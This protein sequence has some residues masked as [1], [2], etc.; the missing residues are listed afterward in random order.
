MAVKMILVRGLPGSGKSTVAKKWLLAAKLET[1][2]YW[3]R[4]DGT[5][6]F[7]PRLLSEAHQWC[8]NK[9][10]MHVE[11]GYPV[12]V[13]NTFTRRW[14]ME[15]YMQIAKDNDYEL[16]VLDLYDAGMSDEELAARCIHNVPV[17]TIKNMRSRYERYET[18]TL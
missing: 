6:D 4:P 7:N 9:T 11:D 15:P 1:D 5:Y 14:E 10:R 16:V 12:V 17:E 3:Y 2:N 8:Q 18:E 13:S